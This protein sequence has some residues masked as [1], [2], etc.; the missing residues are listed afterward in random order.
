MQEFRKPTKSS[1]LIDLV[2]AAGVDVSDWANFRR[3]EQWKAAN[4]KYCYNWSFLEPG[5]VLVACLWI[6]SMLKENGLTFQSLTVRDAP[7]SQARGE[8]FATAFEEGLPVRVIVCWPKSPTTKKP[9]VAARWLDELPW[10]ITEYDAKSQTYKLVRGAQP[11]GKSIGAANLQ[12]E[13]HEGKESV[14]LRKHR[15]RERR[16]REA[17]IDQFMAEHNGRLYCEVDGCGFD[18]YDKYGIIFAEVHHTTPVSHYQSEG[19]ITKLEDLKIVCSNCHRM[20]HYGGQN[21]DL[22]SLIKG[23]R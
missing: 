17:K 15:E 21:R 1:R 14:A 3:G 23:R 9:T 22:D 20:I 6:D 16:L 13:G 18:F 2:E 11:V 5:K 4:P 7:R 19:D 10:A 8:H 12:Y